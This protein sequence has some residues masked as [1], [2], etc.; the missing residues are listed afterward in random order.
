MS[1][2]I[3]VNMMGHRVTIQARLT[4][5][6]SPRAH[7]M[8]YCS[9]VRA[10]PPIMKQDARSRWQLP[11][12]KIEPFNPRGNIQPA[13]NEVKVSIKAQIFFAHHDVITSHLLLAIPQVQEHW[14]AKI[15]QPAHEHCN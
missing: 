15:K 8:M 2:L 6:G 3:Q 7:S 13:Y 10:R 5:Q 12:Y 9:S 14:V 11:S 1:Y 4:M